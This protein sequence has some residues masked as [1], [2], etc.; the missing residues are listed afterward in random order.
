MYT[1]ATGHIML[2]FSNVFFTFHPY[3]RVFRDKTE[4]VKSCKRNGTVNAMLVIIMDQIWKTFLTSTVFTVRTYL[5]CQWTLSYLSDSCTFQNEGMLI[6]VT[7]ATIQ[8]ELLPL[9]FPV[10]PLHHASRFPILNYTGQCVS[11]C[12]CTVDVCM[13]Q[14]I[15][16]YCF[17]T[18]LPLSLQQNSTVDQTEAIQ[19]PS[20]VSLHSPIAHASENRENRE[21]RQILYVLILYMAY[22]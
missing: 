9:L 1:D 17:K 15:T 4:T 2:F 14:K 16:H 3:T 13:Y 5:Q 22:S 21:E 10:C 11:P 18:L 7:I 19:K 20:T 8:F 12:H 6:T